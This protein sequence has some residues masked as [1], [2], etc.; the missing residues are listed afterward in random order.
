MGQ[1]REV[2]VGSES[3]EKIRQTKENKQKKSGGQKK[4]TGRLGREEGETGHDATGG[5]IS[6]CRQWIRGEDEEE[7]NGSVSGSRGVGQDEIEETVPWATQDRIY[8][9]RYQVEL[10]TDLVRKERFLNLSKCSLFW[11]KKDEMF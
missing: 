5:M 2:E 4:G 7:V 9:T 8:S 11:L 3:A 10:R 6:G 1:S